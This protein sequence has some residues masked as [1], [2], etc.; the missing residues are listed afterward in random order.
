MVG[1]ASAE[2]SI[3][4][5]SEATRNAK[6]T[7]RGTRETQTSLLLHISS[8]PEQFLPHHE[9][10]LGLTG[11]ATTHLTRTTL[12][13]SQCQVMLIMNDF[14][15]ELVFFICWVLSGK[16]CNGGS[17]ESPEIKQ[18]IFH[19]SRGF[20]HDADPKST[21]W[22]NW[23]LVGQNA[24]INGSINSCPRDSFRK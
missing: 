23:G 22:H 19:G 7:R 11:N 2:C 4:P 20:A 1:I 16:Q 9:I 6:H 17:D 8:F 12:G 13:K 14:Y 5:R 21:G 24:P 10:P 15:C 18:S 3:L